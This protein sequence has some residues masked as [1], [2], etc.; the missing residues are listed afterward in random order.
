VGYAT[1]G[2]GLWGQL[3]LAGE[4]F[5]WVLDWQAA[6]VTPCND[7][8]YLQNTGGRILRGNSEG[9]VAMNL[10]A[11]NRNT[12]DPTD[13]IDIYGGVRCARGPQ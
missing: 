12:Y 11:T 8:A 1:S 2:A 7:C 10:V 5:A 6:Y 13:R 9:D 4:S 3:D